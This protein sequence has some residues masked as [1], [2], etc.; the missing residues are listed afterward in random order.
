MST[1]SNCRR[2][3][4][5]SC[6]P[7][8]TVV[9]APKAPPSGAHSDTGHEQATMSE[10]QFMRDHSLYSAMSSWLFAIAGATNIGVLSVVA[11]KILQAAENNKPILKSTMGNRKY[12]LIALSMMAFGGVCMAFSNWLESKKVVTEWQL[13]AGKLQRKAAVAENLETAHAQT[14]PSSDAAAPSKRWASSV[15]DTEQQ[16]PTA[17]RAS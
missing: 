3:E 15:S 1:P 11:A 4:V 13:G 16:T 5:V 12:N 17:G 8:K 7:D 14:P 2:E 6:Q 10:K 9:I